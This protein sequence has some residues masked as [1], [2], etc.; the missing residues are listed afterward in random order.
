MLAGLQSIQKRFWK[1]T[2][3][4]S[5]ISFWSIPGFGLNEPLSCLANGFTLKISQKAFLD[6]FKF[7]QVYIRDPE[8]VKH[9]FSV[10]LNGG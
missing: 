5:N 9:F 6:K 3:Y 8:R 7:A 1:S 2:N 10:S 4:Y